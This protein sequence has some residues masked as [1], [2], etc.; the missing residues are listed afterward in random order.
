MAHWSVERLKGLLD[1]VLHDVRRG[2]RKLVANVENSFDD[3]HRK[4]LD[5]EQSDSAPDVRP[6]HCE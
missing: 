6:Q 4:T 1:D 5:D 3:G 2:N